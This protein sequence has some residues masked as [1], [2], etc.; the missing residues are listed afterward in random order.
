MTEDEDSPLL[1]EPDTPA[2][3][4][5]AGGGSVL[6]R[7]KKRRARED[8]IWIDIPSWGGALKARYEVLDRDEVERM[9][10]RAQARHKHR[11]Q[12]KPHPR[13]DSTPDL[14]F[15]IKACIGV[16]AYDEETDEEEIIATGYT[17]DL[18]PKLDPR[19]GDGEPI[20][21]RDQRTL[22]AYLTRFNGIALAAHAQK[23]AR[24]MQDTGKPAEDPQ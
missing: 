8:K 3:T 23:V 6:D 17:M 13:S 10:R 2:A 5:A 1:L 12:D 20:E 18:V 14:D 16:K 7:V 9:I 24:W 21:V 19:D 22:V 11:D 4:V 15:L